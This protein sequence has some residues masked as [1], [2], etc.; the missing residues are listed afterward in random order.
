MHI[1]LAVLLVLLL[2]A[3]TDPF[4]YWMPPSA[5]M[6]ALALAAGLV[7]VFAG[8]ILRERGGDEREA[9]NRSFAG[10]AAYLAGLLVLTS[11]LIAGG[12][13]HTLDPWIPLALGTM[14]VVKV[15][16]RIYADLHH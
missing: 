7:T 1:I 10:R 8:L 2:V 9:V 15:V 12:V 11:A 14:I 6:L 13:S 4:M 3:L 5:G 16:A